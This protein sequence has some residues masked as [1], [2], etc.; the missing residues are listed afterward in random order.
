VDGEVEPKASRAD[1]TVDRRI[2][3]ILISR[4]EIAA[5]VTELGEAI[6]RDY[7]GRTPVLVGVLKGAVVF[8]ADLLR[9]IRMPAAMDF[10]AVSSY[11]SG[12]RSTGVVRLTA[13]LSLSIEDRDVIIVE[14]VIDSGRTISYLRRN[15]ATRHPRSLALCGLLDKVSR[16]EL[17]VDIDYVGFVIPDEFVVGYGLDYDGRHRELPDLAV[18]EPLSRS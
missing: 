8:T 10:M 7:A 15:L 4:D 3:R 17:D 12:T 6:G 18:L 13:D 14:D 5:R 1:T 11:G 2:G 9:A 16:R